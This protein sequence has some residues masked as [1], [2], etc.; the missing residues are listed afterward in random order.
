MTI[1]RNVLL[2]WFLWAMAFITLAGAGYLTWSKFNPERS[3]TINK[4]I[5]NSTKAEQVQLPENIRIP[6]FAQVSSGGSIRRVVRLQ[7]IIPE[8]E[9][10]REIFTTDRKDFEIYRPAR[11]GRFSI[12]PHP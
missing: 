4:P 10:I 8:R 1:N 7:T 9:N 11:I 2:S 3:Q 5:V 6:D 12:I